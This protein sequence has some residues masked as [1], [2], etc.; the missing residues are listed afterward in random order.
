MAILADKNTRLI[1][2]GIAEQEGR[3]YTKQMADYGTNIVGGVTAGKGGEWVNGKPVFDSAKK[4]VDATG[5]NATFIYASAPTAADAIYEAIDAKLSLIV[6]ITKGIPI[7]DMMKVYDYASHSGNRVIGP[8]SPGILTPGQTNIG[9]L[10]GNMGL[11]GNV[12]IV[13]RSGTLTYEVT[14]ALTKAGLGQTTCIG[15]GAD[16]VIGTNFVEILQMFEEDPET[17]KIVL[18]GEIGSRV[19]INAAEYIK[20]GITKRVVAL[21]AGKSAPPQLYMDNGA[22][23]FEGQQVTATAKIEAL[24]EAGVLVADNP[25]QIPTLLM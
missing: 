16:P 8:N 13:S 10:P 18:I 22:A 2:Q 7:I 9:I 11:P 15:I 1:I 25:E 12:G 17:E 14:Y 24:L 19:E 23:I 5:A 21:I 4:A 3:F 20:S 6:C